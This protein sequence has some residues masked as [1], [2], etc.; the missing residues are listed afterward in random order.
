MGITLLAGALGSLVGLYAGSVV[1]GLGY[2]PAFS[3]VFRSLMPLALPDRCAELIASIYVVTY[4]A[5]SLPAIIAGVAVTHYSL[6]K[7]TYVY[8]LLVMFLAA[9]TALALWRRRASPRS[10]VGARR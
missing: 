1:A 7:T 6:R 4:L 2:T 5:F 3:A 10:A 9:M 8:G